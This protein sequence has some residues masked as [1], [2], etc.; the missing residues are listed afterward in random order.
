MFQSLTIVFDEVTCKRDHS[1]E[2][3]LREKRVSDSMNFMSINK[4]PP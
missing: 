1:I 2:C 4:S 3:I